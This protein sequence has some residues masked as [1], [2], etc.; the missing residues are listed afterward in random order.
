[1][2]LT[3][4]QKWLLGGAVVLGVVLLVR[5]N[6]TVNEEKSSA[7]GGLMSCM[8]RNKQ[9]GYNSNTC[10]KTQ[11]AD[12]VSCCRH[13]GKTSDNEGLHMVLGIGVPRNRKALTNTQRRR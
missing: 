2:Q 9:G 3:K 4:N 10:R 13:F 8:C 1:M 5:R 11:H 7:S 6:R 12:C